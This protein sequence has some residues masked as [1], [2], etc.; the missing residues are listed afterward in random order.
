[1][2]SSITFFFENYL[3]SLLWYFGPDQQNLLKRSDFEVLFIV[4]PVKF[5]GFISFILYF[6]FCNPFWILEYIVP[7]MTRLC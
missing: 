3:L 7:H 2:V 5:T 1:M 4:L 6:D